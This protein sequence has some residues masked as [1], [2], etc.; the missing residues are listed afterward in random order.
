M[1]QESLKKFWSKY[2][3]GRVYL[4]L[5]LIIFKILEW[6]RQ[7]LLKGLILTEHNL[8]LWAIC[9]LFNNQG[10]KSYVKITLDWYYIIFSIFLDISQLCLTWKFKKTSILNLIPPLPFHKVLLPIFHLKFDSFLKEEKISIFHM[11]N[12]LLCE[13]AFATNFFGKIY[14]SSELSTFVVSLYSSIELIHRPI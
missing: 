3:T 9:F 6:K 4:N 12:S 8:P 13:N 2:Q 5:T 11:R 1:S 10:Q 7:G 14:Y